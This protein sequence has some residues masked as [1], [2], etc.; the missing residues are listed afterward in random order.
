MG[1]DLVPDMYENLQILMR[2]SVRED[3]IF[4]N[5]SKICVSGNWSV[6]ISSV[7]VVMDISPE[8]DPT[9][10]DR[11]GLRSICFDLTVAWLIAGGRFT[12]SN[13]GERFKLYADNR[14]CVLLSDCTEPNE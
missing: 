7:C 13:S 5:C 6:P 11:R 14:Q 2:L 12:V 1:T 4:I 10:G 8:M 3:S 9:R